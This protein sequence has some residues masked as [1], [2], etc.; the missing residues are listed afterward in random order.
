MNRTKGLGQ[1]AAFEAYLKESLAFLI[2]C[3]PVDKV[4]VIPTFYFAIRS[5][6]RANFDCRANFHATQPNKDCYSAL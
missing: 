6:R 2:C 5:K 3:F 4:L 1:L